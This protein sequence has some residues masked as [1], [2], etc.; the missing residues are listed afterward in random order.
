MNVEEILKRILKW[1]KREKFIIWVKTQALR[2][3]HLIEI[4]LFTSDS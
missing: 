2:F 4:V 1:Q 3:G